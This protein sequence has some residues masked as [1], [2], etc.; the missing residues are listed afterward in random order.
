MC[1]HQAIRVAYDVLSSDV[2]RKQYDE[3][4][5]GFWPGNSR[6][7]RSGIAS[8]TPVTRSFHMG[9]S[10]LHWW[11]AASL[12]HLPEAPELWLPAEMIAI[13]VPFQV[14]PC[15]CR[16]LYSRQRRRCADSGNLELS[17]GCPRKE[18][19]LAGMTCAPIC[20]AT[21]SRGAMQQEESS[22][23]A[24]SECLWGF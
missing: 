10:F 4:G 7:Q 16:H 1:S 5:A 12:L 18:S 6:H 24:L 17:R 20:P 8:A 23:K 13:G 21:H 22:R 19:L 3:Y 2:R 15:M 9:Q 14:A 11:P